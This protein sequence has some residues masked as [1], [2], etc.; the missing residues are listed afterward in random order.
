MKTEER[1]MKVYIAEDGTEFLKEYQCKSYE[2]DLFKSKQRFEFLNKTILEEM[3]KIP[4][5]IEWSKDMDLETQAKWIDE[6]LYIECEE[7]RTRLGY[8]SKPTREE[9]DED[10]PFDIFKWLKLEAEIEFKYGY[11]IK[12]PIY[13]WSK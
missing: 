13:Y 3:K 12:M 9:F 7:N 5:I 8:L 10:C 4:G 2:Q 1:L 6:N 11:K